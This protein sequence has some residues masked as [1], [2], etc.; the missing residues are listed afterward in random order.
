MDRE[1]IR[2]SIKHYGAS[3]QA[4]VC[5]EECSELAVA[6]S[7]TIRMPSLTYTMTN[8]EEEIADVTICIAT[9][10]ELYQIPD[11]KIEGWIKDKQKRQKERIQK[12]L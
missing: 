10:Q 2:E 11:E 6:I 3:V 1:I 12:G 5:M 4:V 9:L 7:K 8:L